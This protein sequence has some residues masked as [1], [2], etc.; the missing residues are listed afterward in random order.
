MHVCA[1]ARTA[2]EDPVSLA[3]LGHTRQEVRTTVMVSD[4]VRSRRITV[5]PEVN[6]N[7]I[8]INSKAVLGPEIK[9]CTVAGP[10]H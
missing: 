7:K 6:A 2:H 10:G 3:R 4:Q 8:I 1:I 9:H 5:A